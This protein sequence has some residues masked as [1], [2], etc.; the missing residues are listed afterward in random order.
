MV[1]KTF[2]FTVSSLL[3]AGCVLVNQHV[4]TQSTQQATVTYSNA[5]YTSFEPTVPVLNSPV[6]K[7]PVVCPVFVPP[8]RVPL[9]TVPSFEVPE[10]LIEE[11]LANYIKALRLVIRNERKALDLAIAEHQKRC[12]G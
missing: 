3:L 11:Q 8:V 7:P 9:P 10:Q 6:L 12:Q 1:I 2:F 5:A 4:Y